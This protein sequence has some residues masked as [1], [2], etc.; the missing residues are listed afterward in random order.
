MKYLITALL[1]LC[2]TTAQAVTC[3]GFGQS[4]GSATCSITSYYVQSTSND[5]SGSGHTGYQV[6]VNSSTL[7]ICKV[8]A[9]IYRF[10]ADATV[11]VEIWSDSSMAGTKYG[12][13]SA[14]SITEVNPDGAWYE[15]EIT[16]SS[17]PSGTFYV[18]FIQTDAGDGYIKMSASTTLTAFGGGHLFWEGSD[19]NRTAQMEVWSMQ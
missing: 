3:V 15:F 6:V 5:Y 11:K 19:L 2:A 9:K 14:I 18:H 1:L 4:G 7:D 16:S 17:N 10:F 8:R 12:E 13:S